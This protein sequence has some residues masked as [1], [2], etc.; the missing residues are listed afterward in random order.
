[1][2]YPS[3]VLELIEKE[4][5]VRPCFTAAWAAYTAAGVAADTG[6]AR[7]AWRGW[8][9]VVEAAAAADSAAANHRHR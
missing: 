1:L 3:K 8:G 7:A 6:R 4:T 5:V 2:K 9:G